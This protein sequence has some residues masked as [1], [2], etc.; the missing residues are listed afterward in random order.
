[1][2][3]PAQGHKIINGLGPYLNRIDAPPVVGLFRLPATQHTVAAI[4]VEGLCP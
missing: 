4:A 1:M 3:A 2:T